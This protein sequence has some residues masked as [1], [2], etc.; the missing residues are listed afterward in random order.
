M[1]SFVFGGPVV[2]WLQRGAHAGSQQLSMEQLRCPSTD[3]EAPQQDGAAGHSSGDQQQLNGRSS[4]GSMSAQERGTRK[5]IRTKY[6]DLIDSVQQNRE[7]LLSPSNNKL[8][9]ILEAADSL[10]ENVRETSEAVLDSKFVSMATELNNERASQM[11]EEDSA[12]DHAAFAEHLLSFM[13]L[14]RLESGRGEQSEEEIEGYLPR[15]AWQRLAQRAEACFQTAPTFHYM[16][17]SFHA[18]PPPPKQKIVRQEKA[19]SKEAKRIMPTQL[20]KMEETEQEATEKEVERILA[21]LKS[22]HQD[23]PTSPISYYE[24]VIDPNSFPRTVENI[25]HT[26]FLVRDGLVQI[27]LDLDK[28]PFIVPV[29]EVVTEGERENCHAAIV[30]ISPKSWK[31]LIEAFEITEPMIP[32]LNSQ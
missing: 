1:Q 20:K 26:S 14:N 6:R 19:P 17:G 24:F 11:R 10:F 2:I 9:E 27:G 16:L 7:D 3:K 25:F 32:P 5:E 12:F 18:E 4:F 31:E 30:T 22:Y 13:G 28:L 21:C 15:D 23:D 29:E 8:T